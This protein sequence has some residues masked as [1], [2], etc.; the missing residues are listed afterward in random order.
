[1]LP[2]ESYNGSVVLNTSF[3][4]RRVVKLEEICTAKSPWCDTEPVRHV[5]LHFRDWGM[6]ASLRYRNG[7]S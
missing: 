7:R 4:N 1:M 5:T 2:E 3:L 6:A